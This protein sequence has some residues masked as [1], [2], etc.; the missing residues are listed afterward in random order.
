MIHEVTGP[1]PTL[2]P[3]GQ[4]KVAPLAGSNEANHIN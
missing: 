2:Y 1:E 4:T 3:L